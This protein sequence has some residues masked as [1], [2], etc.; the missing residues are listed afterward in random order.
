MSDRIQAIA[1]QLG[2]DR[3]ALNARF[4]EERQ[5]RLRSDHS[6][7]YRRAAEGFDHLLA[8]PFVDGEVEREPLTDE[9]D[10]LI[11]GAGFGGMLC[12][13]R[14]REQGVASLRIVEEA[15]DFGGTWYWNRYPGA[16]CDIESYCYLP[17]LDELGYTPKE[18]YS[19]ANEIF[20]VAQKIAEK[21]D[22][23]ASACFRTRVEQVQ[24]DEDCAGRAG[25]GSCVGASKR[26]VNKWRAPSRADRAWGQL[27]T[28]HPSTRTRKHAT[29]GR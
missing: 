12:A 27:H 18:R 24:W 7:Q 11:I 2:I 16:Q 5:K 13:A 3:E 10:V 29:T 15:G 28:S 1:E 20:D 6:D 26:A 8:D 14:L 4:Q 22:L 9:I 23:R 21:F 25:C 19:Y 17:L